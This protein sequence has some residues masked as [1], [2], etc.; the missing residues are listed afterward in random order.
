MTLEK[1]IENT[2]RKTR[3]K[4]IKSTQPIVFTNKIITED[5]SSNYATKKAILCVK[6]KIS[7]I[8]LR[9]LIHN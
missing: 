4:H 9:R 1:L 2:R 8:S 5:I 6:V 3:G 7:R